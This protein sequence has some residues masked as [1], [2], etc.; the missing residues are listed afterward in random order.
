[1]IGGG[2]PYQPGMT[3]F[4]SDGWYI[5]Y[6]VINDGDVQVSRIELESDLPPRYPTA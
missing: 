6:R 1:M 4:L 2:F 3:A 5:A